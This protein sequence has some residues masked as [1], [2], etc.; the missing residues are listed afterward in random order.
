MG[1]TTV[2]SSPLGEKPS[3]FTPAWESVTH[4]YFNPEQFLPQR[5]WGSTWTLV[6]Y[7]YSSVYEAMQS[8][9]GMLMHVE[10]KNKIFNPSQMK[11]R[12]R[13][14]GGKKKEN[15]QKNFEFLHILAW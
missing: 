6:T 15:Q 7:F 5:S 10:E 1:L 3:D 13:N 4:L 12:R 2:L 8:H 11:E 9:S 14:N